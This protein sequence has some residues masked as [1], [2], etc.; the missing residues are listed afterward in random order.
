MKE[1]RKRVIADVDGL[2]LVWKERKKLIMSIPLF[3][4]SAIHSEPS[5]LENPISTF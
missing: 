1:K 3:E 5:S 4:R 2:R